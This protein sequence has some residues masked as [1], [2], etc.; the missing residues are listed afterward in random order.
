MA[1]HQSAKKRIKQNLKRR[2]HNK[3]YA[4]TTRN[5]VKQLRSTT[6]KTSAEEQLPKVSSLLDKLA[7]RNIIHHK[8]AA[9]LKS[10]LAKLVN[11]LS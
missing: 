1:T 10:G 8:K 5:A 6:D 4:R 3:Y 2:V 9:N 11:S 7:R